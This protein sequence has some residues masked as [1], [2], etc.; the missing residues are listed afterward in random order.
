LESAVAL[1]EG[2]K[3]DRAWWICS[4]LVKEKADKEMMTKKGH[5]GSVWMRKKQK[6]IMR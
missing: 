1:A 3:R 4:D 5:A 2:V 6:I